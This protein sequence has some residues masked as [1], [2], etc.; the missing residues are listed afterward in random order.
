MEKLDQSWKDKLS[1]ET[2][3]FNSIIDEKID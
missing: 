1:S 3:R 2:E